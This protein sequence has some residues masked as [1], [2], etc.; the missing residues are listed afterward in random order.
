MKILVVED[1]PGIAAMLEMG[2]EE[3]HFGVDLAADGPTGV[4]MAREHAYGLII[5]DIMLP[6]MDGWGVCRSL[7]QARNTTPILMVTARDSVEERMRGLEGGADDYLPKPFDFKELL[8]RV[9]A[10]SRRDKVH[11]SRVVQ[12]ADLRIDTASWS[13]TRAG[14]PVHLTPREY[15]L[16]EALV[17]NEGRVLTREMILERVWHDDES[18]SGTVNTH[19]VNLR[20]KIDGEH[21]VKLIETVHGVGYIIRSADLESR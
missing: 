20:K 11:K 1:D 10:L 18:I 21:E 9:R 17:L 8:A 7:R 5:L 4:R 12:I 19:M 3:A 13:V 16:L 14:T 6:G 15:T 2:L